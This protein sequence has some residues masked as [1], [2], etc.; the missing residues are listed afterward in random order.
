MTRENETSSSPLRPRERR[1]RNRSFGEKLL[2]FLFFLFLFLLVLAAYRVFRPVL[3]RVSADYYYPFLKVLSVGEQKNAESILAKEDRKKLAAL[4]VKLRQENQALL[5]RQDLVRGAFEENRR[6]RILMKLPPAGEFKVVHAQV[7]Y[8]KEFSRGE[9]FLLD[10]GTTSGIRPGN[11]VVAPVYSKEG[12]RFFLAVAGRVQSVSRH[13]AQ[14]AAVGSREFRMN[15]VFAGGFPGVISPIPGIRYPFAGV[16]FIPL[17]AHVRKGE[18]VKTSSLAGN[19]PPGLPIGRVDSS[20]GTP[21]I[22]REHLYKETKIRPFV[23]MEDLHFASVYIWEVKE[24]RESAGG[25]GEESFP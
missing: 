21:G 15:V 4:V 25:Y 8:R 19:M 1:S 11:V 24:N 17:E 22:T 5:A 20:A 3:E 23:S 9:S 13:T 12:R 7:L 6:M 14:V 2:V 16:T 18:L 10:K